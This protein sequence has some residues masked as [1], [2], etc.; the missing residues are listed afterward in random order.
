MMKNNIIADCLDFAAGE[1]N[2][3]LAWFNEY[4][5]DMKLN[6]IEETIKDND[7]DMSEKQYEKLSSGVSDYDPD[8]QPGQIRLFS[9]SLISLPDRL[10]Y[11]AVISRWEDD[12]WLI[13]PFSRFS[14]PATSGEMATG[15]AE[16]FFQTLQVWN[17]RSVH[18]VFAAKSWITGELPEKIR[19]AAGELFIHL[20]SGEEVADEFKL[21]VG[22][23]LKAELFDP[24]TQYLT[25]EKFQFRPLQEKI[26]QL[27]NWRGK[28]VILDVAAAAMAAAPAGKRLDYN[29][30]IGDTAGELIVGVKPGD[31]NVTVDIFDSNGNYDLAFDGFIIVN[32][33]GVEIAIIRN[34][35]CAF[36]KSGFDGRL[37]L[38][39][40]AKAPIE[41]KSK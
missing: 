35:R 15:I 21:P 26:H 12:L 28:L 20:T 22:A 30:T 10:P 16:S 24:R 19:R 31:R 8:I 39:N 34:G 32:A 41:L 18:T 13:M 27:E 33:D 17:A 36:E 37:I 38:L 4:L 5:L 23:P 14:H 3:F 7:D 40:P 11:F 1:K 2:K 6:E 29:F 25:E 9:S